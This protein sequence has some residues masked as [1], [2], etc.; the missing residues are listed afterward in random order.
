MFVNVKNENYG[1]SV[2]TYGDYVVVSNP[3]FIRWDYLTASVGHTGS[4]EV[5]LYNKSRDEH[6]YVGTIHQ[7]WRELD[8][9]LTTEANNPISASEPITTES[10]SFAFYSHYNIYID[11]DM[12][13]S[14]LENGFG[15]DLDLYE[16]FLVVGTPYLTQL[17][18]TTASFITESWAMVEVYDLA[19]I[20]WTANSASAAAFT[21]DDPDLDS[22]L[23]E[24]GSFGMAVSINR[25]WV[26]IGSPYY[27]GSSGL[28]Y[29]YRNETTGN[30]Y[31][32]SLFQTITPT[33]AVVQGQFGFSLKL[34][35]YDGPNSYS[36]VVGCGNP[37]SSTAYYFEYVNNAWS[38]S[39]VFLPDFNVQP[40]TFNSEYLPFYNLTMNAYN[41]F[42]RSVGTYG[43]TVIVGEPYDRTF[44][45]YSGSSLY[46]QGSTYIFERC[47]GGTGWHQVLKTYGTP[48]TLYNNRMG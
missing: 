38:Q 8:V 35:K 21:I 42:G 33:N 37:T 9:N 48:T 34:N 39:Y 43:D 1:H 32:W 17:V 11:K 13:M 25:D 44:N 31:S 26:A 41:G 5:F 14:S 40:M 45:E 36:L 10:S 47:P 2:A 7:L 20:E 16:K 6:D 22:P 19:K 15:H 23:V 46:Q 29:L 12:Y 3:D 30:N 27:N 18:Q 4:V 28:V 24:T